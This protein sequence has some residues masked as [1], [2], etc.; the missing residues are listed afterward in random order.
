MGKPHGTR[1]L[2]ENYV[3]IGWP[4]MGDLSSLPPDREAFKARLADTHPHTKKGA[5]PVNAGTLFRFVREIKTGDHVLFPSKLGRMLY[6]GEVI[7]AHAFKPVKDP[8]AQGAAEDAVHRRS[9]R[10]LRS[11][12]RTHFSQSALHEIGSFTP[13]LRSETTPTNSWRRCAANP[14]KR[15]TKTQRKRKRRPSRSKS[16]RK[17]SSFGD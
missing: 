10:W 3:A 16:Q 2:D 12:P 17:T 6:I 8:A 5:I 11:F 13:S 15:R 7:G 1:P 14:T 4:A 9:V